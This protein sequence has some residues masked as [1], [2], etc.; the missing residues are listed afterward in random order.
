MKKIKESLCYT[1]ISSSLNE[2]NRKVSD[3]GPS[4]YTLPDGNHI[5]LKEEK[6]LPTE[7]LFNPGIVGLEYLCITNC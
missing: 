6:I 1:I 4:P 2:D 7:I 5:T 3:I